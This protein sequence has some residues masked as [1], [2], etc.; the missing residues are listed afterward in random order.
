MNKA[1][2]GIKFLLKAESFKTERK[3]IDGRGKSL[4]E[5]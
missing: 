2:T 4:L 3:D 5:E 1:S